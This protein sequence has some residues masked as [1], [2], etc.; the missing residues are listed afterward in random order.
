MDLYALTPIP[1]R[2]TVRTGRPEDEAL[3]ALRIVAGALASHTRLRA[4]DLS[5]NALGEKGVR[6]FAAG[7][8]NKV[9]P[10]HFR[11]LSPL[12]CGK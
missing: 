9:R 5:D 3:S 7:L 6:A 11:L 10:P 8:T 12:L 1:P 2:C 4:L